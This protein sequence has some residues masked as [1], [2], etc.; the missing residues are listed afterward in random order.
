MAS[1][2]LSA[3]LLTCTA[4]SVRPYVLESAAHEI[5]SLHALSTMHHSLTHLS[6]WLSTKIT[7]KSIWCRVPTAFVTTELRDS[8]D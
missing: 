8:G 6:R 4:R 5:V 2:T 1:S 3:V 7:G